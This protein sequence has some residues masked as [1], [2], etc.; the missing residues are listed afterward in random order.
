MGHAFVRRGAMPVLHARRDPHRITGAD[1]ANL[2]L[3][4]LHKAMALR[5]DQRLPQR[6]AVPVGMRARL[7][8]HGRAADAGGRFALEA[9]RHHRLAGEMLGRCLLGRAIARQRHLHTLL[10][11]DRLRPTCR[12]NGDSP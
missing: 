2:M 1:G 10:S 9:T 12:R 11:H 6:M 3:P 5:D 4:F 8:G 7:E